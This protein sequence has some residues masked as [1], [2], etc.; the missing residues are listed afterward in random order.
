MRSGSFLSQSSSKPFQ[1]L[2]ADR[3]L[4]AHNLSFAPCFSM[5][6]VCCLWRPENCESLSLPAVFQQTSRYL[7]FSSIL[8]LL[9]TSRTCTL[10][11]S[12]HCSPASSNIGFALWDSS[13]HS[14]SDR[15]RNDYSES[16]VFDHFL[17][18]VRM[19][20]FCLGT[21]TALHQVFI[22]FS[23]SWKSPQLRECSS[24]SRKKTKK[25]LLSLWSSEE[26]TKLAVAN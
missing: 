13:D 24:L 10:F 21:I 26:G 5:P 9:Y 12:S 2:R 6:S 19:F 23:W 25:L 20:L 11:L 8:H 1:F 14:S 16:C 15:T 3:D 17:Y 18:E 7:L 22:G 4:P